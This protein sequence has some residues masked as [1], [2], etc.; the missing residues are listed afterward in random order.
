[1]ARLQFKGVL[2]EGLRLLQAP[3]LVVGEGFLE[4]GLG[5]GG[6]GALAGG[7][8]L[9]ALEAA[10]LVLFAAA[11]RAGIVTTSFLRQRRFGVLRQG[12]VLAVFGFSRRRGLFVQPYVEHI[13]IGV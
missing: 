4:S 13:E 2:I 6:F 11:T 8:G 9:I 1:M 5:R 3:G 10:M 12:S 7:E